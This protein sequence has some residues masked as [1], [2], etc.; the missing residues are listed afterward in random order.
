M[1]ELRGYKKIMNSIEHDRM[2]MAVTGESFDDIVNEGISP[3]DRKYLDDI[4]RKV[5]ADLGRKRGYNK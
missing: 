1:A 2:R 4:D 3:E 5:A